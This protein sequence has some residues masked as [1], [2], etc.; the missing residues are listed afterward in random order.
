MSTSNHLE[1]NGHKPNGHASS[2]PRPERG[3]AGADEPAVPAE[4]ASIDALLR[5]EAMGVAA[6][7]PSGLADRVFAASRASLTSGGASPALG[8]AGEG[9][10]VRTRPVWRAWGLRA[11]A[12][13]AIMGAAA[14]ALVSWRAAAPGAGGGGNATALASQ[15]LGDAEAV[16]DA[17]RTVAAL[18]AL[19]DVDELRALESQADGLDGILVDA[20][21]VPDAGVE[22]GAM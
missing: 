5:A 9:P 11:A 22:T 20:W 13:L 3:W 19:L 15:A 4:V 10:M 12:G 18:D 7:A 2:R 17:L 16:E 21:D 6:S 1:P 8:L 14:A